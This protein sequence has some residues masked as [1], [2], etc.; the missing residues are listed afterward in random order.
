M[1]FTLLY[2][3]VKYYPQIIYNINH[4]YQVYNKY[5]FEK[6]ILLI[7]IHC[8]AA[9]NCYFFFCFSTSRMARNA[10]PHNIIVFSVSIK[11]HRRSCNIHHIEPL[12]RY[13]SNEVCTVIVINPWDPIARIVIIVLFSQCSSSVGGNSSL[14]NMKK[15]STHYVSPLVF[16]RK[17]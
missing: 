5:N 9:R 6:Y 14:V 10:Y 3:S 17:R 4:R 13:G 16:V 8:K 2:S 7:I 15:E 12:Q 1:R 11:I